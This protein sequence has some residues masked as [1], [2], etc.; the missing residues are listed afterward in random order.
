MSKPTIT[1]GGVDYVLDCME[2]YCQMFKDLEEL[3]KNARTNPDPEVVKEN[4]ERLKV[5]EQAIPIVKMLIDGT[6]DGDI[7]KPKGWD[8]EHDVYEKC[9]YNIVEDMICDFCIH[10]SRPQERK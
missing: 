6:L 9:E 7:L 10:C 4:A 8:C 1:K 3:A 2:S 5:W